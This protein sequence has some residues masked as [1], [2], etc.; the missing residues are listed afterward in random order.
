MKEWRADLAGRRPAP[1]SDVR[2]T[3]Q[4]KLV[5]PGCDMAPLR[6]VLS[7][8]LLLGPASALETTA[9]LT[10]YTTAGPPSRAQGC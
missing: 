4:A 8:S 6:Y 9:N 10:L 3:S 7:L 5:L 2:V 1:D